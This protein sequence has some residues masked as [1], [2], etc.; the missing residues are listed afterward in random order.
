MSAVIEINASKQRIR[1][2]RAVNEAA[3]KW[4]S[5]LEKVA[6]HSD[7][8]AFQQLFVH[9]SPLIKAFANKQAGASRG[10]NFS[11]EIVQETM[12]K[13]WQKAASFNIEKA[14]ASTWI[15]TIARNTRIDL[16]RKNARHFQNK[17]TSDQYEDAF[18]VDD[19]WVENENEDVFNQLAKQ[20][21]SE[22]LHESMKALPEEQSLILR[23][24]YLEDK[25]H[26]EIAEELE[27]PLGTVK[28]R[29]RLALNKLSL[30]VDR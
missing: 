3:A 24:V 4:S 25:S 14:N 13:V 12:I 17:A 6:L 21:N 16:L 28:S 7:R 10:E 30:S 22:M 26:S 8:N 9:F 11:E 1:G 27:L 20:R 2:K 23:K 18:D 29:V 5:L 19:I 15:F